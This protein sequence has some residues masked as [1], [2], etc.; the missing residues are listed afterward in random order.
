MTYIF[1][2]P[3]IPTRVSPSTL[4]SELPSA[5]VKQQS[6]PLSTNICK[7]V[8]ISLFSSSSLPRLALAKFSMPIHGDSEWTPLMNY[9]KERQNITY[10]KV[11]E[12][13]IYKYTFIAKM[14]FKM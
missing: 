1:P 13:K 5:F 14:C 3:H 12:D 8:N 7:Y 6:T 4:C 11:T 2:S 9:G 10:D